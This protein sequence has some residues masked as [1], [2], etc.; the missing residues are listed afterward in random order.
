[1]ETSQYE[2]IRTVRREIATT[3]ATVETHERAEL[4]HAIDALDA[5]LNRHVRFAADT[6]SAA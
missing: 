5:W 4:W 2:Q 6:T 3:I 1:M